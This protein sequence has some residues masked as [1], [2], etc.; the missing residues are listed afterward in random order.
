MKFSQPGFVTI[1]L[2]IMAIFFVGCTAHVP[3]GS[4]IATPKVTADLATTSATSVSATAQTLTPHITPEA[5]TSPAAIR[6][7]TGNYHWAEYR[8]NNTVTM[9]PNPRF[10][11]ELAVR[12]E[13]S[14]ENNNGSPAIHYKIT[15]TSDYPEW[16]GDTLVN[17]KNGRIEV[18]ESYYEA[19]TDRVLGKT[20][21]ETIKGEMKP[22]VDFT[23]YLSGYH[24]EDSPGG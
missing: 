20:M 24:R 17:T 14:T 6:V 23:A 1:F 18:E 4:P 11:W 2:V 8:E 16:I 22:E 15:T 19:S 21:T 3:S 12:V 9:P 7:F 5:T 10:Q 13:R